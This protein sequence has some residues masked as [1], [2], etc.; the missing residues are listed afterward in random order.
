LVADASED[1]DDDMNVSAEVQTPGEN[2]SDK[3]DLAPAT[4][5][6]NETAN[7]NNRTLWLLLGGIALA[8]MI[9]LI[10]IGVRRRREE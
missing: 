2:E 7:G 1:S 5:K 3:P 10:L 4:A 9:A 6:D 8:C